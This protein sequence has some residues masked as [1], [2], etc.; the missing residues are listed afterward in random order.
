MS[1]LAPKNCSLNLL[2]KNFNLLLLLF[3]GSQQN[4]RSKIDAL[5][6]SEVQNSSLNSWLYN[7]HY[8]KY[9]LKNKI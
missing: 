2:N 5:V 3:Q 8:T 4:T 6:A 1:T 7:K 9:T